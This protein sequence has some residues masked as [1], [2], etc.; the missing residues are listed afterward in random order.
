MKKTIVCFLKLLAIAVSAEELPSNLS[1]SSTV[2]E[3][4]IQDAV[5]E[6]S[7][8]VSNGVNAYK[9]KGASKYLYSNNIDVWTITGSEENI[10]KSKG[11]IV[12]TSPS[13]SPLNCTWK[14]FSNGG[15]TVM[16]EHQFVVQSADAVTSAAGQTQ[17]N[18]SPRV[19]LNLVH[20]MGVAVL[21]I[22]IVATMMSQTAAATAKTSSASNL[23]SV[24][25]RSSSSTQKQE[26]PIDDLITS[27]SI[28]S[29]V[30]VF[31]VGTNEWKSG[32][33]KSR[34]EDKTY[35]VEF[36]D[37]SFGSKVNAGLMRRQK[38]R[39]YL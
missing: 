8:F 21:V 13:I 25:Q 19:D 37:F 11:T 32:V 10:Q 28:K 7:A 15:W 4:T 22:I 17:D 18:T 30:E 3:K 27:F 34:N 16:A 35:E 24:Q 14:Y 26:K 23:N 39:C 5:G 36:D 12:C 38:N 9:L 6:Y 1:I 31:N 20:L 29:R 2:E 33:V